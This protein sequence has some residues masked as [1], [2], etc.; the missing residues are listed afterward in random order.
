MS[1]Y[2]SLFK[3]KTAESLF[4]EKYESCL[5]LWPV[6]YEEDYIETEFGQTYVIK[7]GNKN[8]PV[9]VLLHGL[10]GTSAGWVP[11]IRELSKKNYIIAVDILGD[12]NK[13]K[14]IK[15]FNSNKEAA[16]WLIGVINGLGIDKFSIMGTSY[17]SFIAMI[18]SVFEPQRIECLI[19]LSPTV[20]ISKLQKEFWFGVLKTA[21]SPFDSTKMH[22]LKWI[23][24]DK[25]LVPNDYTELLILGMKYRSLK[26][27]SLIHLFSDNELSQIK[28]PVLLLIGSKEVATRVDDVKQRAE[29]L[30]KNLTFQIIDDAG[31]TLSSEKAEIINPII[32][33]FLNGL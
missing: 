2:L 13:S 21:V 7:C 29:R 23:N 28:M 19:I 18:L 9:L 5:K 10:G 20:S 16:D 11:N 4:F 32:Q 12:V 33:D 22:F 6:P 8:G 1:E 30:I 31:H 14:A 17:G 26:I 27:K 25:P 3:N 24:A 15:T